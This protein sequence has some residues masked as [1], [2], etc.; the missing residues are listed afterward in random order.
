MDIPNASRYTILVTGWMS[1]LMAE[2]P[3]PN[4]E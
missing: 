1:I 4:E 2:K 3:R